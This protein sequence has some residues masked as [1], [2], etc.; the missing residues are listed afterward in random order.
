MYIADTIGEMGLWYRLSPISFIG[1]SLPPEDVRLGGKN[2]Y[3][4]AALESVIL[5]GPAVSDF[6]ETYAALGEAGASLQ[7]TDATA[8]A[9][10]VV[11]LLDA[12]QRAPYLGAANRVIVE[13]RAVLD[14]TWNVINAAR[15][16][17]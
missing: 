16:G 8:L 15:S 11:Q 13:R 4:A 9:D 14:V 12:E 7:I 6:E 1:H 5:H 2:P 3:E 17:T 10:A